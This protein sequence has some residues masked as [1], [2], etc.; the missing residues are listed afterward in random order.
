MALKCFI[1]M[2]FDRPDTD[3]LYDKVIMP[4]LKR[5][6]ILPFRVDRSNRN[7]DIDDQILSE[8][9]RCDFAIADLTYARPSVYFEAGVAH[10]RKAPV[11]YTCCRDHF[12]HRPNDIH[13]NF[14]V[15]FDLQMKPIIKWSD[16]FSKAFSRQLKKRIVH[17]TRPLLKQQQLSKIA[18]K[19]RAKFSELSLTERL[20]C[21]KQVYQ[22]AIR[23][24]GF[25]ETEVYHVKYAIKR[26]L[27]TLFWI[28]AQVSSSITKNDLM[29]CVNRYT[30]FQDN[31]LKKQ[32]RCSRFPQTIETH[33]FCCSLQKVPESRIAAAFPDFQIVR[34][35]DEFIAKAQDKLNIDYDKKSDHTWVIGTKRNIITVPTRI[36]IHVISGITSE[37]AVRAT[38]EKILAKS[39]KR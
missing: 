13:G 19:E 34:T 26:R 39:P 6:D 2:A 25:K 23:Q 28:K 10:G 7:D 35:A 8:L 32:Y 22:T 21:I 37:S 14:R 36:S 29:Y 27:K 30:G 5:L 12:K 11:I 4:I 18:E 3:K 9:N 24:S 31:F 1:A 38:F 15:H 16:P 17:V 33:I 20:E